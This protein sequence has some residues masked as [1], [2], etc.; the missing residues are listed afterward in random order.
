MRH[1]LPVSDDPPARR[2]GRHALDPV[3]ESPEPTRSPLDSATRPLVARCPP[4]PESRAG[5]FARVPPENAATMKLTARSRRGSTPRR[6]GCARWRP[7]PGW[8]RRP[9]GCRTPAPRRSPGRARRRPRTSRSTAPRCPAGCARCSTSSRTTAARHPRRARPRRRRA[10]AHLPRRCWR[11]SRGVAACCGRRGRRGRPGRRAGCR[12]APPTCTWRSSACSRP[13]RP[14]CRSTPTT[15][16]SGPS[17]SWRG[18][19]VRGARRGLTGARRAAPPGARPA[20]PDAR[21]RRLDHLHLRL[22]RQAQGRRGH[23]PLRG[24]VRRRRGRLF[25]RTRRSAPATGCWPGCRWPSTPPAR[26]CGSPGGTAPAWC[27][28]R[29]S[30]VRSGADLGPVAGRARRSPSSRPCPRWPRCGRRRRWH[31]VRLLIFGGEA[32][33][34]ELAERLAAPRPRGVEHLRPHRGHGRGVRGAARPAGPGADRAAA[35]TAGSWP[36]SDAT[37]RPVRRGRDRRAGHRRRRASPATSTRRRTPRS[38]RRCRRSAG[39]GPTAAATSSAPRRGTL[40]V[41]RADDQVK[42]GGRRIELGEVDA[43]LL[44][45]PGVTAAAAAVRETKAGGEILVGYLAVEAAGPISPAARAAARRALPAALVPLL[46]LVDAHPDPHVGQGRPRGAALAAARAGRPAERRARAR[47]WRAPP[48]GWPSLWH[49]VLGRAGRARLRLLRP[50]RH[51]PRR[52]DRWCRRCAS[53]TPRSPSPTSTSDRPGSARRPP[54]RSAPARC[55][56]RR[57]TVDVPETR[58]RTTLMQ[59]GVLAVTQTIGGLR[60]V[61]GLALLHNLVSLLFHH[62]LAAHRALVDDRRRLPRAGRCRRGGCWCS[63]SASGCCGSGSRPGATPAGAGCICSCGRANGSRRSSGS[64]RSRAPGGPRGTRARSAAASART[65]TCAPRSPITGWATLGADCAVEPGA[66]LAG[67]WIDGGALHVGPIHI[68]AGARIGGRAP[69]C[70]GAHVGAARWSSPARCVD[71]PHPARGGLGRVARRVRGHRRRHVARARRPP[72]V[73][74]GAGLHAF[75]LRVRR[76]PAARRR[77]RARLL[78]WAVRDDT[79]LDALAWHALA[80]APVG[81]LVRSRSTRRCWPLAVRF[82]S[83]AIH[84]GLPPGRQP[85][86]LERLDGRDV[87]RRRPRRAL[88]VLR[89]ADHAVLAAQ[90]RGHDRQERRGVHRHRHPEAHARRRRQL[91]RRRHPDSPRTS[92]AAAGCGLGRASVGERSFV[93]NSGIVG[94]GRAVPTTP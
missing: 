75:A 57:P 56:P 39:R 35:A 54:R 94:P 4:R 92:W 81:T 26:R 64:G 53:A 87:R 85:G 72:L 49:E 86:R 12:P 88:P 93:G 51:Q 10:T 43:A 65:S 91:P 29:A 73:V 8:S 45:L 22:D 32:C 47:T 9:P 80:V 76:G 71:R 74:V 79:T 37:G 50:R 15:P 38:T 61:L 20:R 33:P 67:W 90:A 1:R 5:A 28:R 13:A 46:A 42:L 84:A 2:R 48:A 89:R 19:R 11:R 24:G 7:A 6:P 27:P 62:P 23:P 3:V 17:W 63:R 69:C 59:L 60:W 58:L 44:A 21:R 16:T 30:L 31:G 36:W 14:T 82:L 40:F 41:G 66:D 83:R 18:R 78:G 70:P 77:A 25:L 68:G 55:S 52:G 34:P